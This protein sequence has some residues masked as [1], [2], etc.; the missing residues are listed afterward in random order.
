MVYPKIPC[1]PYSISKLI[2]QWI[3]LIISVLS[4]FLLY[5]LSQCLTIICRGMAIGKNKR[6][7]RGRG[8]KGVKKKVVDPFMR[9]D[10]YDVKAPAT[11]EVR[12]IGKTPVN[13]SAGTKLSSDA[14]KGRVF[15]V[16]LGDL[17]TAN[18][19]NVFRKFKL[20]SED[21]SFLFMPNLKFVYAVCISLV[22]CICL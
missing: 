1:L 10:W 8:G 2:P 6:L 15:E 4:S 22:I 7:T 19:E 14:L 5:T 21:V 16:S 3:I 20:I 17:S 13:K 12:K 18:S 11:F 9:K